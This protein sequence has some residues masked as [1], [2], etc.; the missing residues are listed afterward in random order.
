MDSA[1]I[2]IYMPMTGE[3]PDIGLITTLALLTCSRL[4]RSMLAWAQAASSCPGIS[5]MRNRKA[6]DLLKYP[7]ANSYADGGQG[8]PWLDFGPPTPT[9]NGYHQF[10]GGW[11]PQQAHY[12]EMSYLAHV[13]TLDMGFLE[14]LQY[15]RKISQRIL[16]CRTKYANN[17]DPR[18]SHVQSRNVRQI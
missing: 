10:G 18:E 12:C 9:S 16:H 6:I 15:M 5:G 4:S 14:D 7:K 2:T 17:D 8:S 13:A 1:G 11:T 3:R